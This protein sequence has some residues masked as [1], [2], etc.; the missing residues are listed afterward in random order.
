[1]ILKSNRGYSLVE[2]GVAIIVI[3]VFSAINLALYNST[4]ANYRVVDQRNIALNYAVS[5]MEEALQKDIIEYDIEPFDAENII[6]QYNA[7]ELT[8]EEIQ[9]DDFATVYTEEIAPS[10]ENHNMRITTKLS[11]IPITN[12]MHKFYGFGDTVLKITVSVEYRLKA[13]DAE[14]KSIVFESLRVTSE[15][16][17]T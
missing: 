13:N 6:E 16:D 3:T 9:S 5:K 1:M 11:R 12:N 4:Y 17:A 10:E 2:I 8:L 15:E 7:D 14:W